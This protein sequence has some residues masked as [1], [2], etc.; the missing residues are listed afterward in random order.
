LPSA[1]EDAP[2]ML[3]GRPLFFTEY[4]D[5]LGDEGDLLIPAQ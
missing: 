3:F 5:T 4:C 2:D 1:R